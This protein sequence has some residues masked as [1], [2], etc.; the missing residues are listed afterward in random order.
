MQ[1]LPGIPMADGVDGS[2]F[3]AGAGTLCVGALDVVVTV[4]VLL[5]VALAPEVIVVGL[6]LAEDCVSTTVVGS[7]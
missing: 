4:V 3:G 7:G 5:G 1:V 2:I 6:G